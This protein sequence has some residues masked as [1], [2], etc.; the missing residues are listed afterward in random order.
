MKHFI[1]NLDLDMRNRLKYNNRILH[2][3]A[4]LSPLKKTAGCLLKKI[5]N[6]PKNIVN[7]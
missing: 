3:K 2:N 6:R 4:K 7:N 1:I 5:K